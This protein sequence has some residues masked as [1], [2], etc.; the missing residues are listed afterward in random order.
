MAV[1]TSTGSDEF[2]LMGERRATLM[3]ES[4]IGRNMLIVAS[5][6]REISTRNNSKLT[7]LGF[8]SAVKPEWVRELNPPGYV[9]E[10][11]HVYDRLNKRVVA[12]KVMRYYDLLIGGSP[13]AE[14]DLT[15]A[16]R[17]L[18]EEFVDQPAKLPMWNTQV[19]QFLIT[20][21]FSRAEIVG[22]LQQAWQGCSEF[23]AISRR[24]ILPSL[25]SLLHN[26]DTRGGE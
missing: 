12:G 6:I 25:Q 15:A 7:L 18:A 23:E 3:E 19:R 4:V 24:P 14:I 21:K 17:V 16:A 26:S 10:V 20:H 5:E 13:M 22:A 8:G 1:R 9:E 2:D 11:R